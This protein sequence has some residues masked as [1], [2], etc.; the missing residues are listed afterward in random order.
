MV[1][2]HDLE[3]MYRA[4]PVVLGRSKE[5]RLRVV[6]PTKDGKLKVQEFDDL[7]QA[8]QALR[9]QATRIG[10]WVEAGPGAVVPPTVDPGPVGGLDLSMPMP[11]LRALPRTPTM[12]PWKLLPAGWRVLGYKLVHKEGGPNARTY[13][14][15]LQLAYPLGW[16][17]YTVT[18]KR[19]PGD[20][21]ELLKPT[22]GGKYPLPDGRHAYN[23]IRAKYDS[24]KR[25][26]FRDSVSLAGLT[27]EPEPEGDKPPMRFSKPIDP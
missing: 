11:P 27:H 22:W 3:V 10:A 7:L 20:T 1:G 6:A 12:Y 17:V 13:K 15:F 26:G 8:F 18:F 14:V 9:L 5:G 25:A 19:A 4:G 2:E 24:V 21:W 23:E 16:L